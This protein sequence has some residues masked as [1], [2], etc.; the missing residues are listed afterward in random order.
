[1]HTEIVRLRAT[2]KQLEKNSNNKDQSRD[3]NYN[4]SKNGS[5]G[6]VENR[7]SPSGKSRVSINSDQAKNLSNQIMNTSTGKI[8]KEAPV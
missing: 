8:V 1:M 5:N 6:K 4:H 2:I 3:H 7:K